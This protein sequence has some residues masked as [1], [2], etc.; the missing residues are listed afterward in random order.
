[1]IFMKSGL[2]VKNR[3]IE[4]AGEI[5]ADRGFRETT[6][7]DICRSAGVNL[8]AVNYH[9]GDKE[10]L[11][12]AVI[13][14]YREIAVEKYSQND[15]VR[16]HDPHDVQL[17]AFIKSFMFHILGEGNESCFGKLMSRELIEPTSVLDVII[18]EEFR[19]FFS[20]LNAIIR[21]LLGKESGEGKVILC[22]MSVLGQCLYFK[23]SRPVIS[24]LL[25]KDHYTAEEISEIAD[26][27]AC[28]SLK[29]L[30]GL[31]K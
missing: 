22:S 24:R 10:R 30:A 14:H 6:V 26:H 11:Y 19:P 3:I 4:A 8:A 7:R 31:S 23:H 15:S 5:F 27:I 25:H 20:R 1:M 13:K 2:D 18:E 9:F 17:K 21:R 28:F 12:M 29:A 16:A